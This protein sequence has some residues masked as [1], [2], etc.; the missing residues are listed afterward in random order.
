MPIRIKTGV[1]I[2]ERTR[3]ADS[4]PCV[5]DLEA[6]LHTAC[7]RTLLISAQPISGLVSEY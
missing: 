5:Y 1:E 3:M 2:I 6:S 7:E 4:E